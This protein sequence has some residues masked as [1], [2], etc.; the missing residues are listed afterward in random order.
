MQLKNRYKYKRC[1]IILLHNI[2]FKYLMD[3]KY[4]VR[5]MKKK[6]HDRTPFSLSI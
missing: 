3:I 2:Y 5:K 4:I 6:L 1:N